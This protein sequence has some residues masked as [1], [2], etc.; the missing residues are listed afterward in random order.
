MAMMID[1]FLVVVC[2]ALIGYGYLNHH[3]SPR[4]NGY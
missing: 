3:F 1:F 2:P 4:G